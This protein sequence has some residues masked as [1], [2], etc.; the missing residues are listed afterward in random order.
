M[1]QIAHRAVELDRQVDLVVVIGYLNDV[2]RA[3]RLQPRLG[4]CAAR[5]QRTQPSK[6]DRRTAAA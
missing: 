6:R 4:E 2:H 1:R 5:K 3:L